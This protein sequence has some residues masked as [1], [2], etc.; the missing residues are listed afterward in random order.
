MNDILS[1]SAR[2][3][4]D[5]SPGDGVILDGGR[6]ISTTDSPW[7]RVAPVE[8][9]SGRRWIRLRYSTSYFDEP[10]R[11]LIRFRTQ[12]GERF[13]RAMNGAIFGTAEWIGRVPDQTISIEISPGRRQ[14]PFD[15]RLDAI[16]SVARTQLALQSLRRRQPGWLYW[17]VRSKLLGSQQEAWQALLYA[18][19]GTELAS[20]PL[21]CKRLARSIELEGLDQPRTDWNKGPHFRLIVRANGNLTSLRRTLQSLTAQIYPHW[22]ADIVADATLGRNEFSDSRIRKI[23]DADHSA[24]LIE[25]LGPNDWLATLSPGDLLPD[26]A[27][28]VTAEEASRIHAD[29]IYTDGDCIASDGTRHT[30]VFRPDWSPV[31]HRQSS[32]LGSLSLVRVGAITAADVNVLTKTAGAIDRIIERLPKTTIAHV[33]RVLHHQQAEPGQ[34]AESMLSGCR[35]VEHAEPIGWPAAAVIIPTRDRAELLAACA[36]GLRH[37]TDYPDFEVIVVDNGSHMPQAKALLQQLSVTP[38]FRVINQPGDFNFSALC[39]AGARATSSP[40]LVFLNNDISMIDAQWLK[41]MARWAVRPDVG[42]VGAKLLFPDGRLQHAGVVVGMGGI[43][44]HLC[45]NFPADHPGYE[46]RLSGVHEVSAVTGACIAVAREKFDAIG[47]FDA[48][49]LPVDLN[50]I[51]FCLRLTE[52]GFTN[53]WTPHARLVHQ[54]SATRG[55][56]KDPFTLYGRE[57]SYFVERWQH[58]IRDD[59]Y[60]HPALS[61]FAHEAALA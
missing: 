35:S 11:P 38:R 39:N 37:T 49:H 40:L 45:R 51:D 31:R 43:A 18:S 4:V 61:L 2:P 57:R 41:A 27:L 9:I 33:R 44:G 29:A 7:L 48:E 46:Q 22:T 15:F 16:E 3:P 30:P 26:Y 58:V 42:V 6:T 19:S 56:D 10:I 36:H 17:A 50:D 13:V 14:G 32:I 55:I 52:R 47:G 21:V 24:E 53:I 54:Q 5:L 8:A 28:A 59:P 60:F 34:A 12:S 20:Y 25:T 1:A 23:A